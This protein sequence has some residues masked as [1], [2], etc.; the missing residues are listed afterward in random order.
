MK[1][2]KL[3][4]FVMPAICGI[5]FSSI[6]LTLLIINKET[7]ITDDN[8][9]Y[10]NSSIISKSIPTISETTEETILKPFSSE[11]V[12]IYKKYY[13]SNA[14]ESD[15][16]NSIIF[17]NNTYVQNTGVLYKSSEAFDVTSILDGTIIEIKKDDTL[18][19]VVI[20]KH[21]NNIIS[22]YQGLSEVKVKKDQS[23]K[24]GDLLG[25]SGKISVEENLE[26]ALLI[27]ITK[28][29]KLVNPENM[30]DKKINEI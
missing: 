27:E 12:E 26:N 3:K 25:I 5:I 19:N 30:F 15:R 2:R 28:D 9:T 29:G 1:K 10:V 20:V 18:G 4:P 16:A 13:D 7:N 23:I 8:Y 21:S 24:Q 14:S 6:V 22:T 11:K 17:Y